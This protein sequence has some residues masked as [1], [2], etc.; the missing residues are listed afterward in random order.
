[1]ELPGGAE[2]AG[3]EEGRW[4]DSL[5]MATDMEKYSHSCVSSCSVCLWIFS[6]AFLQMENMGHF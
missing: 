2:A 1:M 4:G 3:R 6:N 5:V